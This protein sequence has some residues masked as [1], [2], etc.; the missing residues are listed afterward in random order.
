MGCLLD[1][2]F[3]A[4]GLLAPNTDTDE[5]IDTQ[6]KVM[7]LIL[8]N[9]NNNAPFYGKIVYESIANSLSCDDPYSSIKKE[10]NDIALSYEAECMQL[11]QASSEPIKNALL[12]SVIGNSIDFGAGQKIDL[13]KEISNLENYH[14]DIAAVEELIAN[15]KKAQSI[16]I[17]GDN[18][19]EIVFDKL[20]IRYL[21]NQFPNKQFTYSVR[22]GPIINDA[23]MDDAKYVGMDSVCNVVKSSQSPGVIFEESSV[24]FKRI[25]KD[26]DLVISK[27]QGNFESLVDFKLLNPDQN[28]YFL[29]KIK[30]KLMEIIFKK[31]IGEYILINQKNIKIPF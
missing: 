2:V 27:G 14:L 21:K 9:R 3:K 17:I 22:D 5:I 18:C 26:A 31:P 13:R 1:Q 10:Y 28:F 20:L 8:D 4:Y 19:G 24:L 25:M 30:C 11:I 7:R 12:I 29:L 15:I 16:F 6:K 23:T